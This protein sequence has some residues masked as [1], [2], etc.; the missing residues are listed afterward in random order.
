MNILRLIFFAFIPMA[1]FC[2][3]VTKEF[4][5]VY[6]EENFESANDLWL[7]TFNI[8][9]LFVAQNGSYDLVRKNSQTGYFILP[10]LTQEYASFEIQAGIKF[11]QNK[12]KK[13]SAGILL[14][15]N[16]AQSS[17]ILIEVNVNKEYKIS[18]IYS[19]K[20]VS[21]SAGKKGWVKNSFAISKT[22]NT[23]SVKTHDMVF[24]LYINNRFITSFSEI[25]LGK[26]L[27]G[28]YIGPDSRASFDFVKV[29]GEEGPQTEDFNPSTDKEQE[30]TLTQIIVKMRNDLKQKEKEIEELSTQ[31]RNCQSRPGNISTDTSTLRKYREVAEQNRQLDMENEILKT[32]LLKAKAEN[33]RLTKFKEE[34][35]KQESGDIVINLTNMVSS[36][37]EKLE[38]TEA[39]K[40]TLALEKKQLET[41]MTLLG[42]Q[43]D[44]QDKTIETLRKDNQVLDSMVKRYKEVLI[45]LNVD[46]D[47]P[48]V[49][50]KEEQENREPEQGDKEDDVFDDEYIK[51]LL[52]REKKERE[53]ER[54]PEGGK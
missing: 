11:D 34:V 48:I 51:R 25:E 19:D 9:N 36:Q 15:A 52:E 35:Q 13:A 53:K 30:A 38:Q 16:K 24:D 17:G 27:F 2:Q 20:I 1:G 50:V 28:L 33:A 8:D 49:P 14:K 5:K 22:Y 43:I 21:L 32:E 39:E 23:I 40:K 10:N 12:N 6:F 44:N 7:Q 3:E 41:D 42:K 18:R 4:N 31:L 37:K 45:L 29:L 46:P 54:K 26:G 47:N